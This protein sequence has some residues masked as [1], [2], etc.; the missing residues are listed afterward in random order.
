[1]KKNEIVQKFGLQKDKVSFFLFKEYVK[2]YVAE[3]FDE[4]KTDN[5]CEYSFKHRDTSSE[6]STDLLP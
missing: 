3:R 6:S 2:R 4:Q 5:Y 1:M